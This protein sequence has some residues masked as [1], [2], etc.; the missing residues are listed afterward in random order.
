ML[1]YQSVHHKL[2]GHP[3]LQVSINGGDAKHVRR[4]LAAEMVG[5]YQ[6]LWCKSNTIC[7][8][9]VENVKEAEF[10]SLTLGSM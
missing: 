2:K 10:V 6:S 3:P 9:V 8:K 4:D 1:V 5:L 7:G